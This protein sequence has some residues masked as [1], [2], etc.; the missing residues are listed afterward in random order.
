MR[1]TERHRLADA[2]WTDRRTGALF[3]VVG[4]GLRTIRCVCTDSI[5]TEVILGGH[6]APLH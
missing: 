5:S 1:E 2:A 4:T 3:S 6:E